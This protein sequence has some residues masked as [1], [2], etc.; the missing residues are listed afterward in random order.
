[1]P[2][3]TYVSRDSALNNKNISVALAVEAA[4]ESFWMSKMGSGEPEAPYPLQMLTDLEKEAGDQ[5]TY[6]IV[7]QI[8]GAPVKGRDSAEGTATAMKLFTDTL[9][10]DQFRKVVDVGDTMTRQR[11]KHNLPQLARRGI[12]EYMARYMDELCGMYAAGRRGINSDFIEPTSFTGH[13]GNALQAPDALHKMYAAV[14]VTADTGL[15]STDKMSRAF[16]ERLNTRVS[17]Q[18]GGTAGVPRMRPITTPKGP[19]FVLVL[20]PWQIYDLKTTTGEGGW[21]DITKAAAGAE[22][23]GSPLFTG[24]IGMIGGTVLQES[25]TI[26]LYGGYGAGANVLGARALML[27]RHAVELAFGAKGRRMQDRVKYFIVDEPRDFGDKQELLAGAVVGV[28]K[29]RYNGMDH[30]IY[31]AESAVTEV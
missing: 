11:T 16:V 14:G 12:A 2:A 31:A 27:G 24:M 13:A 22:G 29:V 30:G 17:T 6:D 1:M 9:Y 19:R 20:H 23:S 4:R 3:Q 10:I 18:G 8:G 15:T 26:T 7:M 5:V 21:L 25:T 28:K